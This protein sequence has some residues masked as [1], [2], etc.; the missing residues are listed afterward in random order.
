MYRK[1]DKNNEHKRIKMPPE[2]LVLQK[3][4]KHR[5]FKDFVF[6]KHERVG[7][8][9][10]DFTCKDPKV[11]VDIFYGQYQTEEEMDKDKIRL[12]YFKN[13]GYGVVR[14]MDKEMEYNI[15]NVY[16]RLMSFCGIYPKQ[17]SDITIDITN[18]RYQKLL[19]EI[20]EEFGD[21]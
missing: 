7:D 2:E 10:T 12:D 3:L 14:I 9:I 6:Y 16:R 21:R 5:K 17:N 13:Q 4:L 1:Y 20:E 8:Y 18:Y 11:I 15:E 19:K